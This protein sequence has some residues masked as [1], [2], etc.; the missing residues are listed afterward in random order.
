M[1]VKALPDSFAAALPQAFLI[2]MADPLNLRSPSA[3]SGTL[4]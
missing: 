4:D 2:N 3:W 1:F